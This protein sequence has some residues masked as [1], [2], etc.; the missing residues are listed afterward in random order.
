MIQFFIHILT[1]VGIYAII[2]MSLNL[3]MG[4][5]G[6]VNF[7]HLGLVGVGA[8]TLAVLTT[9]FGWTF[10]PALIAGAS[11]AG[12][13]GM[14]LSL[15]SKRI[16]GDY[17]ALLTLG[18]MFLVSAVFIN[19][20]RMT[21]GTLGIRGIQ[22]PELFV[23]P[24]ELLVLVVLFVLGT[25]VVLHR[26][27]GSPFGRVLEAIRDD[28]QVAESLGKNIAKAK[29]VAM[30]VSG[31][32]A[33]ISGGLL[34]RAHFGLSRSCS[35]LRLWSLGGLRRYAVRFWACSSSFC[36]RKACDLLQFPQPWLDHFVLLFL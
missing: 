7:G 26:T 30:G 9:K 36:F 8:Y 15:P 23:E 24:L 13:L 32:F 16:K 6:L 3:A 10:I 5:T 14:L 21:R 25:Y 22:R 29:M 1:L 28:D 31:F 20:E 27:V 18:F 17:F 33:G 11:L 2:A 34:I 4:Y 12:L 35:R 19:W